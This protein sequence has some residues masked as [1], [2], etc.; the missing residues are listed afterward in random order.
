MLTALEVA[1]ALAH[2]QPV[3]L[4]HVE[5]AL[6]TTALRYGRDDHYD[7][8]S[9]FIKSMRGSDPDA[10][11]YWLGRMLEAG[12][13]PRFIARRMIIFASEDVGLA[14][15]QALQVAVAAAHAVDHV[16]LPEAQLNMAH[17][18]IRLALAPK[19]NASASAIW[20]VRAA[21][22]EGAVGEVPAHL[23]DAHY[24]GARE[25]YAMPLAGGSPKQLTFEG[26]RAA[27]R[28]WTP[29]GRVIY[30]S[31]DVPGTG[32]KCVLRLIDV[33]SL[34]I[35]TIPFLDAT[36]AAY[37]EDGET[38]Y[39]TR[40]GLSL[41]GDNARQYRGG[42]MAQLW[43]LPPGAKSATR[44]AVDFEAP[45]RRPM[46]RSGRVYFISDKSGHDNIWSFDADGGDARQHTQ[47][48]GWELRAAQMD[49]GAIYYQRGADLYG[50]DLAAEQET[51]VDIKIASDHDDA[52]LRWL[53]EPLTYFESARPD[54]QGNS[55]AVTARG[56][57][58]VLFP[59]PRRRVELDIPV[60]ARARSATVGPDG[61][62][63]YLVL[64]QER[65]GEV[66]RYPAD[67][68]GDPQQL[69]EDSDAHIWSVYPAPDG[70]T[71]LFTD[72]RKRL[73]SLNLKTRVK[74]LL[75]TADC[76]SDNPFGGFAWSTSGRY[77]A[78][79]TR[80]VRSIQRVV[81]RDIKSGRR[82]VVTTG[83]YESFAP[84]F[85]DDARWLYFASNRNFQP[86]PSSPWGDR[87]LGPAFRRRS[88]LYALQLDPDATYPFAPENEL[89]ESKENER[90]GGSEDE[91]DGAGG[92]QS[93]P[94]D[95][96]EQADEI[97]IEFDGVADRL[98]TV[99]FGPGNY[100][101]LAATSDHLYVLDRGDDGGQLKSVAID[102]QDPDVETFAS[103]VAEFGLSIDR[104]TIFYR[105]G[106]G[107]GVKLA[108][109]PAVKKAP[110]ELGKHHVRVGGW[111]L[112]VSP[113]EEWRQMLLDAWR[114]HRE[115]AYDADLR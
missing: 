103:D 79:T 1:V 13:D 90:E 81:L 113:R 29:D 71:V 46:I 31:H 82:E 41:T 20:T 21:I 70:R 39:L 89:H 16:G 92:E 10:A 88:K 25:V 61:E 75:E 47:F 74:G 68:L 4:A 93:N 48:S 52:R 58:A 100:R 105:R 9:A 54:G 72:K 109:V 17:A 33:E 32:K 60:A 87:N 30:Q 112:G 110:S 24:D 38:L 115:F 59:S 99:P 98:W 67:G 34:V 37:S 27:V 95:E 101:D 43:R 14:D 12:E 62:W 19:S 85:S 50:Y 22:R 55:V 114:L 3:A 26:G 80:D 36:D 102:S 65:F 73:W 86:S 57:V 78:Y 35:D 6:G 64:D 104:K 107:S 15:D 77:V 8:I 56:R 66:W 42:T 51:K 69:T 49:N 83:K 5:A 18:A 45:I 76:N 7:V 91:E 63:V 97:D 40:F 2:P 94:K 23:R 28:G 106:N 84:A 111:R 44:L 108:L 53:K 96:Q 11:V